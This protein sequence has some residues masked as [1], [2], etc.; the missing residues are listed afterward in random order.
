MNGLVY[1]AVLLLG[2]V[3]KP[4]S[5]STGTIVFTD[6]CDTSLQKEDASFVTTSADESAN[7][8]GPVDCLIVVQALKSNQ[9]LAV[10]FVEPFMIEDDENNPALPDGQGCRRSSLIIWDGDDLESDDL[11]GRYCGSDVPSSFESS[12]QFLTLYFLLN[13]SATAQFTLLYSSF[14]NGVCDDE[15]TELRCNNG[16]CVPRSVRCDTANNCGDNSDQFIDAPAYCPDT[17]QTVAQSYLPLWVIMAVL[18]AILLALFLYWL[19]WRPGYLIW[20]LGC[21]RNLWHGCCRDL[22][23]KC[24]CRSLNYS[25]Q[26]GNRARGRNKD[27]EPSGE[28]DAD[29]DD[30]DVDGDAGCLCCGCCG[31]RSRRGRRKRELA[32]STSSLAPFAH[33]GL[34][35]EGLIL[36]P[37][38]GDRPIL[39][40][41]GLMLP[42][43]KGERPK[44]RREGLILPPD[45]TRPVLY[46]EG[47]MVPE[48]DH[49]PQL[50]KE[51]AILPHAETKPPSW[52][53][54]HEDTIVP[55]PSTL[56]PPT[57]GE[58]PK[59]QRRVYDYQV[60]WDGGHAREAR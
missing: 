59:T 21:C 49:R 4:A 7:I 20:R 57:L 1:I 16:R 9:Q 23:A 25:K 40:R 34:Y 5:G 53:I 15:V 38:A 6:F 11:I 32:D 45:T 43:D 47:V 12:G 39:H 8:T 60:D 58:V 42:S 41:E 3:D 52:G 31:A 2:F 10:D 55:P 26:S 36:P 22:R 33:P 51:D 54:Y 50:Y 18:G 17:D 27:G 19:L 28:E 35:K 37:D 46:R 44:L 24:C 56:T 13:D 48:Y 14:D 29:E 30:D